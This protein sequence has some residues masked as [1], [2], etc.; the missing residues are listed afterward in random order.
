[1]V[2][3]PVNKEFAGFCY[4]GKMSDFLSKKPFT[5]KKHTKI[6]YVTCM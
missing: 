2:Q 6:M 5:Y 4:V 3:S 1:M